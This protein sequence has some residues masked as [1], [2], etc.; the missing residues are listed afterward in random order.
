MV[1]VSLIVWALAGG[2]Y[3]WPK[4]VLLWAAVAM[5]FRAMRAM[6]NDEVDDAT[7]GELPE[8]AMRMPW[9]PSRSAS[10]QAGNF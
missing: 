8:A 5:S 2:G 4:W 1:L 3:F 6:R 10:R 7:V 9:P